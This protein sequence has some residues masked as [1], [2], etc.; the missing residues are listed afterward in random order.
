M[1]FRFRKS[2]GSGPFRLTLSKR[3]IST[4]AGVKGARVSLGADGKVRRTVGIPGSGIYDTKV[5]GD[6]NTG[7]VVAESRTSIES[8][9]GVLATDDQRA[10]IRELLT[11]LGI[12]PEQLVGNWA[13]D[14]DPFPLT[15]SFIDKELGRA[16][17]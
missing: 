10:Q 13:P 2:F 4:S 6:T 16:E 14:G 5:I 3:G 17:A 11:K 1:G 7:D 9:P 8:E 12:K 15:H